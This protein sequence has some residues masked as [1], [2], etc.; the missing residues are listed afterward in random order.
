[1]LASSTILIYY[2]FSI[3]L[4]FYNRY[5]FVT[6]TYPL[7]ITIIHLI[8]KFIVASSIRWCL[9]FTMNSN[10]C[11]NISKSQRVTLDWSIYL[12]KMLPLGLASAADIGFSNW[13]LQYITVTL[14]T[15]SKSTVILFILFFALLFQL[16]KWRRSIILIVFCISF[17]LFLFTFHST[18][19]HLFGFI[20][21]MIASLCSGLRWTLAQTLAQKH[22]LGLSN[23]IDMIYH[24][25]PGMILALLPLALYVEGVSVISTEKFF[26]NDDVYHIF[27]NLKWILMGACIAFFLEASEFLVVTFTSSLTLSVSG[28]FK[29]ICIICIAV[30]WNNNK[31]N[32]MNTVGLIICLVG[33][34]IHVIVKAKHPNSENKKKFKRNFSGQTLVEHE[35]DSDDAFEEPIF[36]MESIPR[37]RKI[38]KTCHSDH[39]DVSH[40][41]F[42]SEQNNENQLFKN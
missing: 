9:N 26:R 34:S 18:E 29:E 10:H 35:D 42:L 13:S 24:I 3:L 32:T 7:S 16:E 11:V 17:G 39:V 23:P 14:Y 8:I 4:T 5:L 20:L 30:V 25:Q 6:Y 19:F 12:K 41:P 15:M 38:S 22:E 36:E 2:F 33:I 27:S 28:I 21:V 1:M 40:E 37:T 31:L